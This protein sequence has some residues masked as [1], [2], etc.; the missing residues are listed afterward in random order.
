MELLHEKDGKLIQSDEELYVAFWLAELK[1][2]GYVKEY[3]LQPA[4]FRLSED[5]MFSWTK[6]TST[7][8]IKNR[9]EQKYSCM[10]EGK[11]YTPDVRV[12]WNESARNIFYTINIP[13]SNKC[14]LLIAHHKFNAIFEE[15]EAVSYIEVKPHFDQ[16]NMEREFKINQ[17]WVYQ[18]HNTFVNLV[19]PNKF[20]PYNFT[21][22]QCIDTMVYVKQTTTKKRGIKYKGDSKI[23]WTVKTLKEYV[24]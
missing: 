19:V 12:V 1:E 11:I 4:P 6:D 3:Q 21:P 8:T 23:T 5:I 24:K 16:N 9:T 7:K 13:Q 15:V 17:K 22:Q 20:F 14:K 10:L 2:A 18:L